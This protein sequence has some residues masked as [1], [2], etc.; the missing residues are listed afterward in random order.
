MHGGAGIARCGRLARLNL[1]YNKD[2]N[3]GA[4]G[5]ERVLWGRG[6]LRSTPL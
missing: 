3:V 2:R 5:T 6:G 1:P 4:K